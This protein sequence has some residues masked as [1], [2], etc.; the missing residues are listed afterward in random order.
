MNAQ[1]GGPKTNYPRLEWHS[2]A[3]RACARLKEG[4]V[5]IKKWSD[6]SLLSIAYQKAGNRYY[7][8]VHDLREYGI[9]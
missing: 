2:M 4:T 7:I 8:I 9:H 6:N 5:T 1:P 3:M